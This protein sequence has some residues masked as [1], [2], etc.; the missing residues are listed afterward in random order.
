MDERERRYIQACCFGTL[1]M[2]VVMALV[3]VASSRSGDMPETTPFP[4][5][6]VTLVLPVICTILYV[7][8]FKWQPDLYHK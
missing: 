2:S 5:V 6:G 1:T 3:Y 7:V 4:Y 8:A